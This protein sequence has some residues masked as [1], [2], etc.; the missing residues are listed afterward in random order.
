MDVCVSLV[1]RGGIAYPLEGVFGVTGGGKHIAQR[2][3]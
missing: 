2:R 1:I 3:T